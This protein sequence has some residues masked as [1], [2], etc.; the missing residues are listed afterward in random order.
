MT[1]S[2]DQNTTYILNALYKKLLESMIL[3]KKKLEKKSAFLTLI[4]LSS[5]DA[6]KII[7]NSSMK[8]DN[9]FHD[10]ISN[11]R[12]MNYVSIPDEKE[13]LDELVISARGIWHIETSQGILGLN[14]ILDYLQ[15]TKLEFPKA[16]Q[17]LTDNE[18]VI[19]CSMLAIRT[20]SENV[21]MDL[22]SSD[23]CRRWQDIIENEII[24]KLRERNL[25]K[26]ESVID[27][28]TGNDPIPYLLRHAN[29]LPQKT[30]SIFEP[31]KRNKYYLSLNIENRRKSIS[32]ITY[33]LKK[34][35]SEIDSDQTSTDIYTFL[36]DIAHSH[37][38][39]VVQSFD[40]INND[41]DQI[42]KES[43]EQVYL[44]LDIPFL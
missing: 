29:D 21:N 34:I 44:G 42:L 43:L 20:F 41:W 40:F 14:E 17:T 9:V 8:F 22:T 3:S 7:S 12:R 25:I 38:L 10:E 28:R 35:F 23:L 4:K 36:C 19:I 15:S 16:K 18:K 39:F 6:Y 32:Q 24:P 37:S 30:N 27:K 1:E 31:T 26:I 5:N 33:L 11:L 13:K 2:I